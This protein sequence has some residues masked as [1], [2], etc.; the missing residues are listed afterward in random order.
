[1]TVWIDFVI[2]STQVLV[3]QCQEYL[4]HIQASL[5]LQVQLWAGRHYKEEF[6]RFICPFD[7]GVCFV[8]YLT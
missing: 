3:M 4:D 5:T 1:M 2:G 6:G 7:G 8:I